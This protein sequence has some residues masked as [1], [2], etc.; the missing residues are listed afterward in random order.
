MVRSPNAT[1]RPLARGDVVSVML[2]PRGR[3][4]RYVGFVLHVIE[5][6]ALVAVRS[7]SDWRRVPVALADLERRRA[8]LGR[9]FV[10]GQGSMIEHYC[11]QCAQLLSAPRQEPDGRLRYTWPPARG[12]PSTLTDLPSAG[13]AAK[14]SDPLR[15]EASMAKK[16]AKKIA[17]SKPR[18][19]ASPKQKSKRR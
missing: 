9:C 15:Q 16:P 3:W 11:V 19:K 7:G 14:R 6:L 10:H 12:M 13:Y 2:A 18:A 8:N 1:R 5:P 17:A 4:Q